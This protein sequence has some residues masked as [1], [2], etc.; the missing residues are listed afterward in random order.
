MEEME[1]VS[2]RVFSLHDQNNFVYMEAEAAIQ[3][4]PVAPD[5]VHVD[6][7]RDDLAA[8]ASPCET[9]FSFPSLRRAQ[10]SP[11]AYHANI[12]VLLA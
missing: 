2:S 10:K 9:R 11:S 5:R 1:D 4:T 6:L 7:H 8:G 3:T 12:F